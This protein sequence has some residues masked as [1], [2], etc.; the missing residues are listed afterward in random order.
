MKISELNTEGSFETDQL[1]NRPVIGGT[2]QYMGAAG[3]ST[4]ERN[5]FNTSAFSDGTGNAPNLRTRFDLLI[6]DF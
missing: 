2:G 1:A 4:Q 5:G 3:Q 6:P